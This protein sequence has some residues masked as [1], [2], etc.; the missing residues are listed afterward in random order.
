MS[1]QTALKQYI[2]KN[3]LKA[4]D[5][6]PPEGKL[7]T[8]LGIGRNS[9]REGIKALESLGL[10]EVRRGVGAFVKAFTL[11]PLLDHL[12]YAF[13]Q[14]LREVEEILQI[15]QALEVSL[16]EDVVLAISDIELMEL[17]RITEVMGLKAARG[18]DFANE[19]MAFHKALFATLQNTMLLSLLETFW[20]VF[21]RVSGR[22]RLQTQDPM[23]TYRDHLAILDAVTERDSVNAK[24]RLVAHYAGI[25]TRLRQH[26]KSA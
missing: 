23:A 9:V 10:L 24:L 14:G 16:I 4:G 12:P 21:Y 22:T 2:S 17:T 11:E 7:A 26:R 19:D 1:V 15:R 8:Q 13:G 20:R 25:S 6:L 3:D 5:S 18:E